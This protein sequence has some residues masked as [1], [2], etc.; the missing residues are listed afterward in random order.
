MLLYSKG[1]NKRKEN[2]TYGMSGNIYKH[3]KTEKLYPFTPTPH[4]LFLMSQYTSFYTVY[5]SYCSSEEKQE[6]R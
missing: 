1:K 5:P 3:V 2:E 4:I 6:M